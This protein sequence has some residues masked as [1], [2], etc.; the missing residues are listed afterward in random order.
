MD[1]DSVELLVSL[2]TSRLAIAWS[3]FAVVGGLGS[4]IFLLVRTVV[5]FWTGKGESHDRRS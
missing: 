2:L 5:R 3:W 4:M 1:R